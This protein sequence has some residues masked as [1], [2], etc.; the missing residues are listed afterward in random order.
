MVHK[1]TVYVA[2]HFDIYSYHVAKDEWDKLLASEYQSFSMVVIENR[3]TT[4]GGISRDQTRT[5]CLFSL[6]GRSNKEWEELYP[7]IPTHRVCAAALTTPTHLIVAGGRDRTELCTIEVMS[8]E[9]YQWS[10]AAN[11]PEPMGSLQMVLCLGQLYICMQQV[12]YSYSLEKL[13]RSCYEAPDTSNG[14]GWTKLTDIPTYSGHCLSCLSDELLV[15]G[16]CSTDDKETAAIHG[17]DQDT[18][19]W[20]A[21]GEMPTAR[22]DALTTSVALGAEELVVVVGGWSNSDSYNITEIG[23]HV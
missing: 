19:T 23:T 11:L 2:R 3:L 15:V 17:Y 21:K 18:A 20:L 8:R 1:D 7:P 4:I 13:L 6:V 10:Q 12:F 16:G 22:I 9:N 5:N 14:N